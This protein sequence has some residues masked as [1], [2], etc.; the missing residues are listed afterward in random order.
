[1]AKVGERALNCLGQATD[2]IGMNCMQLSHLRKPAGDRL[3]TVFQGLNAEFKEAFIKKSQHKANSGKFYAF[4]LFMIGLNTI[5]IGFEVDNESPTGNGAYLTLELIFVVTFLLEMLA[6]LHHLGWEYFDDT[7]NVLDYSLVVLSLA[8]S[9][10]SIT[11]HIAPIPGGGDGMQLA[12][13]LRVFR[14]LR[15]VR[16]IKG[17]QILSG[18]WLIIQGLLESMRTVLWVGCA[19]CIITY[20]FAVALCTFSAHEKEQVAA[21]YLLPMYTGSVKNSMLTIMQVF[22]FDTWSDV[23]RPLMEVAPFTGPILVFSMV[24]L[25]FGTLNILVGVMVQQVS[26]LAEDSKETTMKALERTETVLMQSILEDF[27]K[28]DKTG[29]G[30]FD[31]RQFKK[32]IRTA[33]LSEKLLLLAIRSEDAE[34]LFDLLDADKSGTVSAMEFIEGLQKIKGSA[35]GVDVV[36][37]ICFAQKWSTIKRT[38]SRCDSTQSSRTSR[39][40]STIAKMVQTGTLRPKKKLSNGHSSSQELTGIVSTTTRRT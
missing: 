39:W 16:S 2:C 13:S 10:V 31:L 34:S 1:M 12:K 37:L 21:W 28:G 24:V 23:A 27:V 19:V 29:T 7:W 32:L 3:P 18:L 9:V 6:R 11:K 15:I 8:D 4:I 30:E 22:T 17:L 36:Q 25:A 33:S 14:L 40:S 5:I 20:T 26:S 38:R 35:K